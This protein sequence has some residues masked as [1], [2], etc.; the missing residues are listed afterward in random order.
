ME[1]NGGTLKWVVTLFWNNSIVFNESSIAS[2]ITALTLT[3]NVNGPLEIEAYPTCYQ[4]SFLE[5]N[6]LNLSN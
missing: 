5:F 3:L 2:I 6:P 1:N 4:L